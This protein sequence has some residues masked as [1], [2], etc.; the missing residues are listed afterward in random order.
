MM[1]RVENINIDRII[2]CCKFQRISTEDLAL[3]VGVAQGTIDK[4]I[5]R[6]GTISYN[7]LK[8]I[9]D[10]FNRGVLFFLEDSPVIE[11]QV[12]SPAFRTI[13][14]QKVELDGGTKAVI[15]RAEKQRDIYVSLVEEEDVPPPAFS[16]PVISKNPV[17]A[18]G[19]ARIWL[20]LGERNDFSSFRAAVENKGILVFL[21][22]GYKGKWQIPK[23]NPILGFSIYDEQYPLIVVKKARQ[24]SRQSFTLM[25]EL[26]HIIIHHASIIDDENDFTS[27]SGVERTANVFAANL[28]VPSTFLNQIDLKKKPSRADLFDEW[29]RIYRQRWGVSTDVLLLR[30]ITAQRVTQTEYDEYRSWV[31]STSKDEDSTG[32]RMYRHR[33]PHN[34]FGEKYVRSVLD[35]LDREKITINKASKFL[36]GLKL[37]DIRKLE[38]Y[39]ASH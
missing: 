8:K 32:T 35:A 16:H 4:L 14:N 5:K 28:L 6:E 39:R 11:S 31:L 13:S 9:A 24:E 3:N 2:W 20:G 7:Q 33:E 34:I 25:H 36:D 21:T 37:S 10:Y 22:N 15:E 27:H 1:D 23:S 17:H 18:A 12:F 19:Q 30:L 26:S 38:S 29:L